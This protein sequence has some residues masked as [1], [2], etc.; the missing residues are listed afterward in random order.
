[1]R[2]FAYLLLINIVLLALNI[3]FIKYFTKNYVKFGLTVFQRQI[4][5]DKA[6]SFP[7]NDVIQKKTV[8]NI[9]ISND[10]HIYVYPKIFWSGWYNIKTKYS[11]R[12]LI[13]QENNTLIVKVKISIIT[14][15]IKFI[16]IV[17]LVLICIV[18]FYN[19]SLTTSILISSI[20]II[21]IFISTIQPYFALEDNYNSMIKE[22]KEVITEGEL[23]SEVAN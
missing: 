21:A 17:A 15:I 18:M 22:L 7:F 16:L 19:F 20:T 8:N 2:L 11:L 13:Y 10:K 14:L 9:L 12:M 6:F 3:I 23:F 4:N 1:M 5:L